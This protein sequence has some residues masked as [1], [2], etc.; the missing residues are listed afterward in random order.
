MLKLKRLKQSDEGDGFHCTIIYSSS[1]LFVDEYWQGINSPL[2]QSNWSL[3]KNI[4][5][6][7]K[8]YEGEL[9]SSRGE[10]DVVCTKR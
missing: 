8:Y 9:K 1:Y 6:M 3:P 7:G 5:G 2:E 10:D 4:T